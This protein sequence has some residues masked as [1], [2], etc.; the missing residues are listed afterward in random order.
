[1][2]KSKGRF[3]VNYATVGK[4]LKSKEVAEIVEKEANKLGEVDTVYTGTQRTWAKGVKKR[5]WAKGVKND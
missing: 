1:M 3:E 2:S 4:I 5:T